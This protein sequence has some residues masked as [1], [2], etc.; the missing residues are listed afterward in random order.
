MHS[1]SDS[2]LLVALGVLFALSA[3]NL[4]LTWEIHGRRTPVST[5][6]E[7][8]VL[9]KLEQLVPPPP[10][11]PAMA[12]EVREAII[13]QAVVDAV[14]WA[15]QYARQLKQT[16]P[17]EPITGVEKHGEALRQA[18]RRLE[19]AGVE[20]TDAQLANRIAS[21]FARLKGEGKV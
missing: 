13:E 14:F 1:L 21:T 4:Y 7:A 20:L 12:P 2:F 8:D 18:K 16:H 15:E 11:K 3:F 10:P 17:K 9:A 6:F 5:G 19:Q